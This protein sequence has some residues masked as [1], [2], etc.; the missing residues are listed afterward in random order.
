MAIWTRIGIVTTPINLDEFSIGGKVEFCGLY[1]KSNTL[2]ILVLLCYRPPNNS[3]SDFSLFCDKLSSLLGTFFNM[4]IPIILLGDFNI[5]PCR[6]HHH[7]F[8]LQNILQTYNLNNAIT[9]PT[10]DKFILDHFYNNYT[11]IDVKILVVDNCIS[12]HRT[13]LIHFPFASNVFK[14]NLATHKRIYSSDNISSFFDDLMNE[15]WNVIYHLSSFQECFDKFYATFLFYFNLHFPLIKK[16]IN[17]NRK[18]WVTSDVISS[19]QN[20][21]LLF[22]LQ[23]RYPEWREFYRKA[24]KEH[25]SLVAYTKR[26]HYQSKI[27][28]SDNYMKAAWNV[29]KELSHSPATTDI[30]QLQVDNKYMSDPKLIANCFNNFFINEPLK[31]LSQLSSTS[32]IKDIPISVSKSIFL[33]PFSFAEL[34]NL[35]HFKLKNSFSAGPDDIP[36]A[37]IKAVFTA[38]VPVLTF[39]INKS[40]EQGEFPNLLKSSKLIPIFKKGDKS[41]PGNYR[42]VALTSSFSK[43]FEYC[44][45]SRLESFLSNFNILTDC[46]HGFRKN[47]STSTAFNAF[48]KEVVTSIENGTYPVGIFLDLSK[49]FDCVS[50]TILLRKLHAYGIRGIALNWIESFLSN[51]AQYVNIRCNSNNVQ[52]NFASDVVI[53]NVGVPQGSILGPVLFLVF[54]N[55]FPLKLDKVSTT[56][57]ADDV[58]LV[59]TGGEDD[60]LA[61]TCNDLLSNVCS[62][63]TMNELLLNEDKSTYLRFHPYQLQPM[64]GFYLSLSLNNKQLTVADHTKFLGV[65]VDRSLSWKT[66]CESLLPKINSLCFLF[67]NLKSILTRQQMFGMYYAYVFSRLSYG[68]IF[69]G[70]STMAKDVFIGQKRIIRCLT[71]LKNSESCR[72]AC[73]NHKLLTLPCIFIFEL[74][75]YTFDNYTNFQLNK[76]KHEYNTRRRSDIATPR[77][78]LTLYQ[79]S[80]QVL[81][82]KVFN[83]LPKHWKTLTRSRFKHNVFEL[84]VTNGFYSLHEFFNFRIEQY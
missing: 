66:H 71:D 20:L 4:H 38:L 57:Y 14:F 73:I 18:T 26:R 36:T 7:N 50:H 11:N 32:D 40:F 10:R 39:L 62:W 67:R 13:I 59:V 12:D 29:I 23:H 52:K 53:S 76:D 22:Q 70:N 31:I 60:I 48:F 63:F 81:A 28:S 43:V 51:R 17:N 82:I 21:K 35:L 8:I 45:L 44:F 9:S 61:S 16:P 1:W 6:D 34:A 55:D 84:L 69:W 41:L 49:A 68:I 5:D 19:S 65:W 54:I 64:S 2:S 79:Q 83:R 3:I 25:N 37:V 30:V 46:Q 74:A 72:P 27:F 47:R 58:A 15:D 24:K 56:L 78:R 77:S 75:L 42:P 80:P 33:Y